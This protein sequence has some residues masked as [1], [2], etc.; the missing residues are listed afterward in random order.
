VARDRDD[1]QERPDRD[2]KAEDRE[3]RADAKP[4][5]ALDHGRHRRVRVGRSSNLRRRDVQ[6]VDDP[7]TGEAARRAR[8]HRAPRARRGFLH[9]EARA[10]DRR[11]ELRFGDHVAAALDTILDPDQEDDGAKLVAEIAQK[12]ERGEL[13]PTAGALEPYADRLP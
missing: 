2:Y 1:P 3:D 8:G 4:D 5:D 10:G 11:L 6:D 7:Q 12:L 13:E 9:P